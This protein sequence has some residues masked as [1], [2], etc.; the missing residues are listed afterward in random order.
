MKKTIL[1]LALAIMCL[2]TIAQPVTITFTGRDAKDQPVQLNRVV[3]TNLTQNWQEIIYYPDTILMMGSTGIN[4]VDNANG[5][6]LSQNVPNPFDGTT[7][8]ALQLPEAGKVSLTVYDLNGK[9]IT[10]YQGKLTAGVH[11]FRVLLNTTQSYLLTAR[12]GNETATIKMINNGNAGEN[13]IRYLG[14]GSLN[15]LLKSG[16]KGTTNKPFA[17]GDNMVYMGYAT[18]NGT[19]SVSQTVEQRQLV[20]ETIT[21][22]FDATMILPPTVQTATVSEIT[23]HSAVCGG[24]VVDDGGSTVTTR[25]VCWS[26]QP[27]P[28]FSE[29][30]TADGSGTGNFVS[31]LSGL[32]YGTTYYVRAYAVN[33]MG[34]AY[35]ETQSFMTVNVT[36]PVVTTATVSNITHNSATCGGTVVDMGATITARGVCWGTMPNPTIGEG[37]FT[38]D[39]QGAGSFVSNIVNLTGSTLYYVRAYATTEDGT[40]YGEATSFTTAAVQLP[41]AVTNEVSNIGLTSAKCGGTVIDMGTLVTAR[42]VCWNTS[43]NP[44]KEDAHTNDGTGAGTFSSQLSNLEE[45][46]TYYVRAYATNSDGTSYGD[47]KQFTTLSRPH[48]TTCEISG[49]TYESAVGGGTVTEEGCSPVTV[50]G[51]CWG[52]KPNPTLYYP[53]SRTSNGTGTGVFSS[54]ITGLYGSTTYYVRAYATNQ[55]GTAY[56]EEKS[57]TTLPPVLPTVSINAISDITYETAMGGGEVTSIGGASIEARGVCWSTSHNPTINNSKTANGTGAGSF[58]SSL[59]GLT[60]GTTY[61]M[62]AYATNS[63]GTAYSEEISFTTKECEKVKVTD[64]DGNTY[65]TILIGNQCWMKEN[66]RTTKYADGTPISQGSGPSTTIAYWYYPNNSSSNKATYGLL[67]N[68]KA[69]MRNA[70]SSSA[71]PSGVQGIC[72]NGWHIPSFAETVQ[73]CDQLGNNATEFS[74]VPAGIY[75]PEVGDPFIHFG[76]TAFFWT[77]TQKPENNDYIH[78]FYGEELLSPDLLDAGRDYGLSVRCLKD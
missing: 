12:C 6:K 72:P 32:T 8:F 53:N 64:N 59:T 65:S 17:F 69:V 52:T 50:R 29:S 47:E 21:L 45:M 30:H 38:N 75:F 37:N 67:Y 28:V 42:G 3:I 68:W 61:Y 40:F 31:T 34:V 15:M 26:T 76:L 77:A 41:V 66:L 2:A 16:A 46:T 48:V 56:G 74:V 62:R 33:S 10:A 1:S 78:M 70:T 39:G 71:N 73:L 14:E 23:S 54:D 57:F 20:S 24:N 60:A 11:T 13:A 25:G 9:K 51:V 49:L 36:P 58:T 5:F 19:E 44:T 22:R 4:D 55:Q 63:A 18:I 43:Q 7:D 35:G 27:N